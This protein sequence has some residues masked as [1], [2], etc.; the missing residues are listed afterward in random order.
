MS[1][2]GPEQ[3]SKCRNARA[4]ENADPDCST[5]E[6][7]LHIRFANAKCTEGCRF[8]LAQEDEDWIKLVLITDEAKDGNAK[9]DEQLKGG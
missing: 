4:D 9:G 8:G 7:F 5:Q 1:R 2:Y 6:E 3:Q